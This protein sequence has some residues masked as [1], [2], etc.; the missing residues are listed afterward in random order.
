MMN[1]LI[2]LLVILLRATSIIE[3]KD[4]QCHNCFDV[5]SPEDCL[6]FVTCGQD[7]LC[8]TREYTDH[9]GKTGYHLG[10]ESAGICN[11]LKNAQDLLGKRSVGSID[12]EDPSQM[13]YKCCDKTLCN[14]KVCDP[15]GPTTTGGGGPP[16]QM[17]LEFADP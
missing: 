16:P 1:Q 14:L 2:S 9:N 4:L 3:S 10:C 5:A 11:I 15:V 12:S 17:G 7:E 13:C 8:Y 6:Q